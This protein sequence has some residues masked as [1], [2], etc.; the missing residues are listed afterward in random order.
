MIGQIHSCISPINGISTAIWNKKL[1]KKIEERLSKHG[2]EKIFIP[3]VQ[4]SKLWAWGHIWLL[5]Y[6]VSILKLSLT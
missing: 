1:I 4:G 2:W 5:F 3:R 6:N